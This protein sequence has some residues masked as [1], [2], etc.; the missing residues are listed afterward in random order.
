MSDLFDRLQNE[1]DIQAKEDGVTPL[2]LAELPTPLRRIMRTMLRALEL[3]RQEIA[4]I[5]DGL[6]AEERKEVKNLD[7]ALK[8]LTKQGWLIALGERGNQRY[9]VNLRRKRGSELAADIFNKLDQRL[10][11]HQE[12]NPKPESDEE[13]KE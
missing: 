3:D 5:F 11:E 10:S 2:D 12:D 9:K 13:S 7:G 8:I 4:E 1:L 6:P